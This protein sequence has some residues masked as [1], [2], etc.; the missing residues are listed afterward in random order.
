MSQESN[1]NNRFG[2]LAENVKSMSAV[3]AQNRASNFSSLNSPPN[4]FMEELNALAREIVVFLVVE[5]RCNVHIHEPFDS[6]DQ[7]LTPRAQ[8]RAQ[9]KQEPQEQQEQ[10]AQQEQ[11]TQQAQQEPQEQQEQSPPLC[12]NQKLSDSCFDQLRFRDGNETATIINNVYEKHLGFSVCPKKI[13]Q[14]TGIPEQNV[15]LNLEYFVN[16]LVSIHAMRKKLIEESKY[17]R[18]FKWLLDK[19]RK[20]FNDEFL[21]SVFIEHCFNEKRYSYYLT[22]QRKRQYVLFANLSKKTL[23]MA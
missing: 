22:E 16:D 2:V 8:T 17:K 20:L 5:L 9:L 1:F 13:A 18:P 14:E 15:C 3:L 7:L 21:F 19:L 12:I 11:Q 23:M 4:S 6:I 10:Q